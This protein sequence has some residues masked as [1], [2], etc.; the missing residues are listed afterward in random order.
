M[1]L[2]FSAFGSADNRYEPI[3]IFHPRL[4]LR[5]LIRDQNLTGKSAMVKDVM[6]AKP[7]TIEANAT[8][9]EAMKRMRENKVGCLPV[10]NGKE[11]IGIITEMD[12]LRISARLI[13][14]LEIEK[15]K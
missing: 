11:L 7:I 6:V 5:H 13:E 2:A 8:I 12:F 4:I 3:C 14:R 10:V 1:L 9:I 15:K